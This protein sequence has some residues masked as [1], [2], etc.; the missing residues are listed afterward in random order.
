MIHVRLVVDKI[1]TI[2]IHAIIKVFIH[3]TLIQL[4]LINAQST[5]LDGFKTVLVT[6]VK[7]LVQNV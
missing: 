7:V 1:M 4:V 3:S 5:T 6:Y 2:A